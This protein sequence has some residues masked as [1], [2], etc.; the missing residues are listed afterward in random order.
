MVQ[1]SFVYVICGHKKEGFSCGRGQFIDI[2]SIFEFIGET[3]DKCVAATSINARM[4]VEVGS[5]GARSL[6]KVYD[7]CTLSSHSSPSR[8][9]ASCENS[10]DFQISVS[11]IPYQKCDLIFSEGLQIHERGH[12]S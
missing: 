6:D 1:E 2:A 5:F 7:L 4:L 10:R 12:V 3:L 11:V 9:P 8:D